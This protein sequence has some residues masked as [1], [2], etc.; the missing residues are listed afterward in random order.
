MRLANHRPAVRQLQVSLSLLQRLDQWLFIDRTHHEAGWSG[1]EGPTILAALGTKLGPVLRHQDLRPDSPDRLFFCVRKNC[2][3]YCSAMPTDSRA[4]NGCPNGIASA[5]ARP[6]VVTGS[7]SGPVHR[8]TVIRRTKK[9]AVRDRSWPAKRPRR[10]HIVQ[11][12]DKNAAPHKFPLTPCWRRPTS[13][14]VQ[15]SI[16]LAETSRG[17]D[18]APLIG[19]FPLTGE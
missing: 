11:P 13:R 15:C 5:A 18:L 19:P 8:A 12:R 4:S 10:G 14:I 16:K 6:T 2:Q 7:R 1:H 9:S 17:K 3:I